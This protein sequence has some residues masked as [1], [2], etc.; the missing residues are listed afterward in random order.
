MSELA[1][2]KPT[3]DKIDFCVTK[4]GIAKMTPELILAIK[5]GGKSAGVELREEEN[6]KADTKLLFHISSSNN[7][8]SSTTYSLNLLSAATLGLFAFVPSWSEVNLIIQWKPTKEPVVIQRY[9]AREK[10]LGSFWFH[11][12]WRNAYPNKIGSEVLKTG[13]EHFISTMNSKQ[14]NIYKTIK[15]KNGKT[16]YMVNIEKSPKGDIIRDYYG[17]EINLGS[18]KIDQKQILDQVIPF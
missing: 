5:E 4:M 7:D 16:Y 2:S 15:T 1:K 10:F 6:C 18:D 12:W 3:L 11:L 8:K 14:E 13:T 9:Y 17:S